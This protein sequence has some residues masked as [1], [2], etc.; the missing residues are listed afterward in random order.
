MSS[1]YTNII[2]VNVDDE[3]VGML[4][5]DVWEV[6]EVRRTRL[7]SSITLRKRRR[8]WSESYKSRIELLTLLN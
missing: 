6:M 2:I 7:K 1:P 5:G 3:T 4:V 8:A